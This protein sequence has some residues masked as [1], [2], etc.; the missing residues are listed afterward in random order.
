AADRAR[1]GAGMNTSQAVAR[2][3]RDRP[4]AFTL[5]FAT[6]TANYCSPLVTGWLTRAFFDGL[7]GAAPAGLNPWSLIALMLANEL[8][9]ILTS[10]AGLYTWFTLWQSCKTLL[11]KNLFDWLLL[12]PGARLLPASAGEA[13]GRFRDG[14]D[15][16]MLYID[17]WIDLVGQAA[18]WVVAL[19]LTVMIKSLRVVQALG[20]LML[21]A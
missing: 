21:V 4:L 18:F 17:T 7:S 13:V 15:M 14:V 1:R 3:L 5:T 10:A 19:V 20:P 11:R 2:L 9:R 12:G 8:V 16:F 6:W